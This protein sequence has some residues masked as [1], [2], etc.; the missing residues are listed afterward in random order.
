MRLLV[1]VLSALTLFVSS[2]I[3]APMRPPS[4]TMLLAHPVQGTQVMY[5]SPSGD[6]Y[7]WHSSS[8]EVLQGKAYYGM[9]ERHI[10][11][12]F[13]SNRYNPVTGLPAGRTEC[14]PERDLLFI[15]R[16]WV[17]GDP[18]GLSTSRSAPAPLSQAATTIQSLASKAG[19]QLGQVFNTDDYV[20]RPGGAAF[21]AKGI[22][23][24]Y[25]AAGIKQTNAFCPGWVP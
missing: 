4:R 18:F 20:M 23:D 1:I 3:A 13:G 16:Q 2:A 8:A 11:L 12:R 9:V 22:C 15:M 25:A 7:L 17:A 14:V 21:D 19:I 24:S 5:I 10:C 6:A